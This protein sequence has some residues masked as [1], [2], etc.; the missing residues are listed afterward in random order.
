MP[1]DQALVGRSY[2]PT[3]P[4]QVT[5]ETLR[6]FAAAVG[7][8]YVD[9]P[10]PATYPIVLAGE[11]MQTFLEAEGIDLH[12][13]VHGEQRFSYARPIVEG[14]TLTATLT[15]ASLRAMG[16]ADII[17]TRSDVVDADGTQVCACTATLVHR[18]PEVA[19]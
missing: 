6:G 9:G 14:D 3:A 5:G 13:I 15:V 18:G 16:G 8:E 1:V 11:A 7:G 2:P 4:H 10:A 17:G 12:R 19:P